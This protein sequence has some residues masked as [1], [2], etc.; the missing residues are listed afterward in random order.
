VWFI[1]PDGLAVRVRL[2]C[3]GVGAQA[4]E[5]VPPNVGESA[6]AGSGTVASAATGSKQAARLPV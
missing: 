2:S 5:V 1:L 3:K 4:D 6:C